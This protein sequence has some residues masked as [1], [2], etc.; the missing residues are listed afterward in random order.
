MQKEIVFARQPIL[1]RNEQLVAYELLFRG[2]SKEDNLKSMRMTSSLLTGFLS[3]DYQ[4]VLQDK[5][6]YVNMD[7]MLIKSGAVDLIPKDNFAI[8]ILETV[9]ILHVVD[10]LEKY[11][12][13]GYTL[14][15]DDF[16]ANM[17]EFDRYLEFFYLFD[18]VKFD[19]K[20][21]KIDEEKL[22]QIVESLRNFGLKLLA[23]KVETK[24]EYEKYKD[25]G[26]EYFQGYYFMK[27]EIAS[28]KMM[29]PQKRSILELW[30]LGEDD[31]DVIVKK[32]AEDPKLSINILKLLNSSYFN[33][34]K[35]VSSISQALAY[36][37][38]RNFK[39]WLLLMLYSQDGDDIET[40]PWL[41]IAIG[42]GHFMVQAASAFGLDMDKAS[43]VGILSV[44]G[45]IMEQEGSKIARELPSLD[46]EIV[47]AIVSM[48]NPY[49]KLLQIAKKIEKGD[50]TSWQDEV[51][52]FGME[53]QKIASCYTEAL[54]ASNSL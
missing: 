30:S 36:L 11:K 45:E 33:L 12:K 44:F 15:L 47:D 23:E 34:Q 14:V 38:I 27:P 18:V 48:D 41:D 5:K 51:S 26:F 46:K 1:D 7:E 22:V 2:E 29:L 40:N 4:S 53:V 39:K 13:D 10:R 21:K 35:E 20:A 25:L 49:G 6:G 16:I 37:G 32:L 42:R 28:Q 50:F 19:T 9:E 54:R 3:N 8:E 43:L 24:E 52:Q 17:D 31:F